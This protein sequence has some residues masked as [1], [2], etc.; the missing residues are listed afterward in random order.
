MLQRGFAG[1][2]PS[3]LD[4]VERGQHLGVQIR[5]ALRLHDDGLSAPPVLGGHP[6]NARHG[7]DAIEVLLAGPVRLDL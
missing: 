4:A 5:A 1:D 7:T 3:H 6:M 2:D